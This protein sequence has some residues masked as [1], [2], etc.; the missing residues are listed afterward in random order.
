[1]YPIKPICFLMLFAFSMPVCRTEVSKDV[2][3]HGLIRYCSEGD[4]EKVKEYISRGADVN[5]FGTLGLYSSSRG[6]SAL[7]TAAGR[8]DK[9]ICEYLISKGANV[10]LGEEKGVAPILLSVVARRNALAITI[11]LI[12]NGAKV[13]ARDDSGK[14]PLM[15]VGWCGANPGVCE[16]LLEH[17]ADIDAKDPGRGQTALM[18]ALDWGYDEI[19]KILISKGANF[20]IEDNQGRTALKLAKQRNK[21]A[22]IELLVARGAR[23]EQPDPVFNQL[24]QGLAIKVSNFRTH[25]SN[26]TVTVPGRAYFEGKVLYYELPHDFTYS[27][28]DYVSA[29]I[30]YTNKLRTPLDLSIVVKVRYGTKASAVAGGMIAGVFSMGRSDSIQRDLNAK[31]TERSDTFRLPGGGTATHSYRF[32]WPNNDLLPRDVEIT[33]V[34][35][36]GHKQMH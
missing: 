4:L 31:Q 36:N 14:T 2:L 20:N 17:G 6:Y 10:N 15:R 33:L 27:S 18:W 21:T 11:M 23:E 25:S 9:E 7:A 16:Y 28:I 34:S 12:Q 1:M 8:G 5:A 29:N 3:N 35:I 30:T 26:K 13:N 32:N 22:I 19:A 24:Q